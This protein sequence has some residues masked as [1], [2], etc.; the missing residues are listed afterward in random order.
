MEKSEFI[1]LVEETLEVGSGTISLSDRLAEIDW[2]SLAN[3]SF[4][5]A[6]DMSHSAVVDA[7]TLARCETV[8]DL[9]E[10]AESA[11]KGK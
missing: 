3:I 11:I 4:I 5:A 9:F 7:E 2:D 1:S 10:L 8:Q 6:L